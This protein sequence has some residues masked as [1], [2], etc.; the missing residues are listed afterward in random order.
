MV[1]VLVGLLFAVVIPALTPRDK[2]LMTVY[3]NTSAVG[4]GVGHGTDVMLRGSRRQGQ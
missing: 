1:A 2:D 4:S 3:V